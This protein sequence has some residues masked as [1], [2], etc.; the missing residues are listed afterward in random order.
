MQDKK[1][2]LEADVEQWTGSKLGREY[3]KAAFWHPAYVAYMQSTSCRMPGWMNHKV[4]LRLL[5][6]ISTTSDMQMKPR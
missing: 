4:E 3:I 5:R 6:E 1:T 2:K